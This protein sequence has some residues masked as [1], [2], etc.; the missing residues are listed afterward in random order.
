MEYKY[1]GIDEHGYEYYSA[2]DGYVYQF[3]SGKR[4]SWLCS[5]PAWY[6]TFHKII[7]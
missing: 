1:L 7:T 5:L 3:K 4:Q 6:R 2:N